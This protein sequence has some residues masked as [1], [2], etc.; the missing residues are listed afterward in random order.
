M[1]R[2][3]RFYSLSNPHTPVIT[4]V[5]RY[6]ETLPAAGHHQK[7]EPFVVPNE[8]VCYGVRT[9]YSRFEIPIRHSFND[10]RKYCIGI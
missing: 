9:C 8:V 5:T 4:V 3:I 7:Q 10:G 1:K 2:L 6:R